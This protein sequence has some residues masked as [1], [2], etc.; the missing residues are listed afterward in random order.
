MSDETENTDSLNGE[1]DVEVQTEDVNALKEKLA[2]V[3]GKN[4]QLFERAKKA[5][6]FEKNDE[7]HWVKA[8]KPE[9]KKP[10][11][12]LKPEPN[13]PDYATKLAVKAFLKSEGISHPDDQKWVQ[14]EAAR[15]KMNPDEILM[16]EHVKSHLETNK[17]QR[18]AIAGNPKGEGRAGGKSQ[19]D[20]AFHLAQGTTPE[21]LE[22]AEKVIDA[23]MKQ[24]TSTRMFGDV[25]VP[26]DGKRGL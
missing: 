17:T 13:E 2:E 11:T 26:D 12:L 3:T 18:E 20:V 10:E 22:L 4:K 23:R 14:D 24:D 6:G 19:D 21:D 15:L 16:M 7:G 5:E 1:N 25:K 8:Q 9:E